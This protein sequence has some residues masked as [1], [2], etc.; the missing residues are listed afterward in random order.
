MYLVHLKCTK[1]S[2]QKKNNNDN[3][4]FLKIAP[5]DL[6]S[7]LRHWSRWHQ[8][9]RLFLPFSPRQ[10]PEFPHWLHRFIVHITFKNTAPLS[11][12]LA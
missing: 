8:C 10:V 4:F 7:W 9:S 2:V 1:K 6:R 12:C 3:N 5:P 11:S